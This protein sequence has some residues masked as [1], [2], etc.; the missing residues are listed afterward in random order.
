[1]KICVLSSHTSSMFWYRKDMMR[2]FQELGHDVI[3]IGNEPEGMWA[4]A[5]LKNNIRY[6][7]ARISRNAVNPLEDIKT[8]YDLR[9]IMQKEM[10]DK[11][12][13]YQA[14]TMIYG[15]LAA[16]SLKI[17]EVYPMVAGLGS[18]FIKDDLKTK[19]ICC[20]V[21]SEYRLAFRKKPA[22]FFQNTDDSSLFTERGIV[23]EKQVVL[24]NGSGVNLEDFSVQALPEE[25]SFLFVGRLIKDKG[26]FEYLEACRIVK[27]K[28]PEC[29]CML[30]GPFDTNPSALKESEL[31]PYIDEKIIEYFGEQ[32]DV[33]PY[34]A[35]C[36]IFVLPSYREG[37]PKAVLE[38]MAMGRAVVTT[39]A[40]GCRETVIEGEN[41]LMVPIKDLRK[42]SDAMYKLATAPE[43]VSAMGHKSRK[44]AEEKFD[45]RK[46][47][48][49]ISK[50]MGL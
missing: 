6:Y 40:P 25:S 15:S 45:V 44:I 30:V 38:A 28:L 1:M 10:P 3:A 29:R 7:Q 37:T 34:I 16:Q 5:F 33:R 14:K 24:L 11:L 20:L 23:K 32:S 26:I 21:Q 9:K 4:Q 36:G 41:G 18:I 8:F 47:N 17:R 31:Q 46:V 49:V 27:Q 22:V 12:F 48:T 50:T 19:L 43:S 42:L 35:K 13:V 39:D 2:H